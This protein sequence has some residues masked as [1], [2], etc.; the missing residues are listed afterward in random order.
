MPLTA[1]QAKN[2]K[3]GRHSD[4]G[5]LYLLV[6]PA[7]TRSWM[8]RVQVAGK[9]RDIGLGSFRD[10]TL[11]EAREKAITARKLA[12]AGKDPSAKA[13]RSSVSVPTFEKVARRFHAEARRGWRNGKHTDQWLNTL[14]AY[15]FPMIG[16]RLPDDIAASDIYQVLSPIWLTK[17]ET[18]RRVR[19]RVLAV[20]DNAQAMGWRQT[21]APARGL[22]TL[23]KGLRQPIKGHF[24][25]MP[26]VDVPAFYER[27][28]SGPKTTGRLA[29][30]FLLLTA[31]RSGEVRGATWR[32]LDLDNSQWVI[33]AER[34]KTGIKHI[35]PLSRPA[36]NVLMDVREL[37]PSKP[38]S[39]I[40]PGQRRHELSDM[41]LTKALRANGG[42]RF[43]V[44]GFRSSFRD[45]AA[46]NGYSNDWAE[47]ALSHAVRN[48][49]EAAYRR[50]TFLEQRRS[51]MK[52]WGN[53]CTSA[54]QD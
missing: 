33:P 53:F 46:E 51:L 11:A 47:A 7:G 40:F 16:A 39:L 49:T 9:R 2:A 30:R 52:D 54:P 25:A 24:P 34:M 4:G 28:S 35:V 21:D 27:L 23:L 44:H 48:K 31:A 8:L 13:Q 50:T 14:E 42:Q 38:E 5:G 10:V 26:Y 6:T 43:T 37:F 12:K 20:L 19:Q 41:T 32:E 29:L 36:V 1:L 18:A 22:N 17:P 3:P 45:W 15:V